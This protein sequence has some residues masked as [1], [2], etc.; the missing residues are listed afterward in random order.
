MKYFT[1]DL[2][3][4][5][6]ELKQLQDVCKDNPSNINEL[7]FEFT[8]ELIEVNRL[9]TIEK[10]L[11]IKSNFY[12]ERFYNKIIKEKENTI[13]PKCGIAMTEET[14]Q[15]YLDIYNEHYELK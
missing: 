4:I 6:E 10:F 7:T 9:L 8:N 2:E 1:E 12:K 15:E 3:V 5:D 14:F 13:I 11:K